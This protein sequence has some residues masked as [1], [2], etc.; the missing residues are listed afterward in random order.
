M[1]IKL[2]SV[3]V[4]KIS[5]NNYFKKN[6]TFERFK[7]KIRNNDDEKNTTITYPNDFWGVRNSP[8]TMYS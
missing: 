3:K 7:Q 8:S 5:P 1:Q 4:L 2:L 6:V